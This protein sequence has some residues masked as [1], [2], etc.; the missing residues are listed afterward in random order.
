[1][2]NSKNWITDWKYSAIKRKVLNSSC[3]NW[4]V[5]FNCRSH[6]L[7]LIVSG[8]SVENK[9]SFENEGNELEIWYQKCM[10]IKIILMESIFKH[11]LMLSRINLAILN[12]EVSPQKFQLSVDSSTIVNSQMRLLSFKKIMSYIIIQS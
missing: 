6:E 3:L 2:R 10:P 4:I 12:Q 7:N 11:T 1:M 5:S 8:A 9:F